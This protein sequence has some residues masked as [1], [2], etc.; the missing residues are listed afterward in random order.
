MEGFDPISAVNQFP[1]KQDDLPGRAVAP[2]QN[3]GVGFL[4]TEQV[5]EGLKSGIGG[6]EDGLVEVAQDGHAGPRKQ[7]LEKSELKRREV[8]GFI[9]KDVAYVG[10][11]VKPDES[12]HQIEEGRRIFIGQFV[13]IQPLHRLGADRLP[14]R[15]QRSLRHEVRDEIGIRKQLPVQGGDVEEPVSADGPSQGF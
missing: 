3:E 12:F 4:G 11:G 2:R 13:A 14:P 5:G 7:V 10:F 15:G 6:D 9:D 8:L 1:G